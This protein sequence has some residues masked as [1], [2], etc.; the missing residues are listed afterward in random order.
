VFVKMGARSPFCVDLSVR[1]GDRLPTGGTRP[2]IKPD[3]PIIIH[4]RFATADDLT[5]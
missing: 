1:A 3:E 5:V 4:D 2:F